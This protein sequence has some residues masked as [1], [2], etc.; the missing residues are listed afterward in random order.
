MGINYPASPPLRFMI[1]AIGI[2]PLAGQK[3]RASAF[4]KDPDTI[5]IKL[6]I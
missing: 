2:P 5:Y 1:F 3:K 6:A 4:A